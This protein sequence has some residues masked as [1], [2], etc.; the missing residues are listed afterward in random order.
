MYVDPAITIAPETDE[1]KHIDYSYLTQQ[2]NVSIEFYWRANVITTV[3]K[4]NEWLEN[5]DP[6]DLLVMD[7]SAHQ[8]KWA[9]NYS[10]FQD[11]V[12]LLVEAVNAW[13]QRWG[14]RR[15]LFWIISPAFREEW[16]PDDEFIQWCYSLKTFNAV[17]RTAGFLM[18]QGPVI[19]ID[20]WSIAQDCMDWCYRD[21]THVSQTINTLLWQIVSGGYEE[22]LKR[23]EELEEEQQ[24]GSGGGMSASKKNKR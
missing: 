15:P 14:L 9:R 24:G 21:G 10:E 22:M 6:P 18:P 19:P 2:G 20:L 1:K 4:L 23:A 7:A 16:K 8:A 5:G 3:N 13:H 12:P 17:L 11:E